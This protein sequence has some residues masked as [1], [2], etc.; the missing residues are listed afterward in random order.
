M[1][2]LFLDKVGYGQWIIGFSL[3]SLLETKRNDEML[4]SFIHVCARGPQQLLVSLSVNHQSVMGTELKLVLTLQMNKQIFCYECGTTLV[5]QNKV[6]NLNQQKQK[7]F[8]L[9][10]A[11]GQCSIWHERK[12]NSQSWQPL[13]IFNSF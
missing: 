6:V 13:F 10:K 5:I 3:F 12:Q 2:Q 7:K 8:W 4:W 1:N 11:F 9:H